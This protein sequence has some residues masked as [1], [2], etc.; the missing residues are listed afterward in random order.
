M[1]NL[2]NIES[3]RSISYFSTFN[4]RSLDII[5]YMDTVF[6]T[7]PVNPVLVTSSIINE[8]WSRF[9]II[10]DVNYNDNP[11]SKPSILS[12]VDVNPTSVLKRFCEHPRLTWNHLNNIPSR[13]LTNI[14]YG[15]NFAVTRDFPNS[16]QADMDFQHCLSPK[17]FNDQA[18]T[19]CMGLLLHGPWFTFAHTEIGGGASYALLNRGMKFWCAAT[20]STSSRLLERCCYSPSAFIDLMLRGPREREARYLQFTIQRPGDLIYVPPLLSHAVLTLDTGSPTILSGWDAASTSNQQI[21]IQTL[22][23]YTFGVRRG[24]WRDILRK[25]GRGELRNWVFSP[26]KGPQ[27]DK[28]RLQKHWKYWEKHCPGLLNSLSIEAPVTHKKTT[29]RPPVQTKEFRAAHS[30]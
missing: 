27:E 13:P 18:I 7:V 26:E 22:D 10:S 4:T 20:S 30:S 25:K 1:A 19:S 24:E 29:R 14:T 2:I 6:G 15:P 28:E 21:I 11:P 16:I 23:E 9:P 5:E 8:N 3:N 17:C 12:N